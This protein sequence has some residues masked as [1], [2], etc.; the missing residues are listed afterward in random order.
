M[1]CRDD[2]QRRNASWLARKSWE[3]WFPVEKIILISRK[4][5]AG[6]ISSEENH[7]DL[8]EMSCR[9]DFQRWNASWLAGKSCQGWFPVGK[10]ILVSRK[11]LA[12]M[13]S[14]RWNASWLA[15]NSY[16]GCI[17]TE[18]CVPWILNF[19]KHCKSIRRRAIPELPDQGRPLS[20]K[21]SNQ[22]L[23]IL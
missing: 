17:S 1:S 12:G 20:V 2:F 21:L 7:P 3:G 19:M 18:G 5:H 15:G 11:C 6:M 22:H 10:C 13:I 4:C 8:K 23:P 16:Q 9:D 14:K